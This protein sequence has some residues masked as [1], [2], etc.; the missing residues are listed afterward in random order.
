MDKDKTRQACWDHALLCFG[1][2]YIFERRANDLRGRVRLLTFLGIVVPVS[3]GSVVAS[4]GTNTPVLP[5]VLVTAGVLSLLQLIGSVWSLAAKWNDALAYTMKSNSTNKSLSLR[6]RDLAEN[7]P[8]D[9]TA[10]SHQFQLLQT[11][12]RRQS[13]DDENQGVTEKEK[14]RGMR[15][16]LREFQR[17]CSACHKVPVSMKPTD[18]DVCGNF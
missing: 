13:E 16:G 1:T 4:F 12:Y 3:V 18:C 2:A 9:D 17:K 11:E 8:L 5:F 14:R 15:A 7:P 10:F 6:Y